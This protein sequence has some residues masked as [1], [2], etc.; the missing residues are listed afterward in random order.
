M[1]SV[2]KVE[3]GVGE[4]EYGVGEVEYGVGKV[5]SGV[6]KVEVEVGEVEEASARK[7]R[8][9][10]GE[11]GLGR[12]RLGAREDGPGSDLYMPTGRLIPR[13]GV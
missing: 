10:R 9:R 4:V 3:Y 6:E 7:T 2:G 13:V 1:C 11:G 8:R 5:E 12:P